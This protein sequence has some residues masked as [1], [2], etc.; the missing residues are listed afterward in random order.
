MKGKYLTS[1]QLADRWGMF[2]GT[3][4]NWRTLKKGPPFIKIG[5]GPRGYVAYDIKD[6]EAYEKKFNMNLSRSS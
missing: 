2:E 4:R 6:I 5:E 3:I 1:K